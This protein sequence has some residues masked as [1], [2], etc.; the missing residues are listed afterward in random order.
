M[1]ESTKVNDHP[2]TEQSGPASETAR[3]VVK[4]LIR[5]S[6]GVLFVAA[7]LFIPAGRLDWAMGWALVGIYA[8][9]VTASAVILIPRSPELLAERAARRKGVRGWDTALLGV[10]GLATVAKYVI[11]G[12]DMRFGWTPPMPVWLQIAALVIAAL[13]YALLTWSMAANA[14]FSTVVRIQDDRGHAVV[15]GGPYR[16]VRHPGYSGSLAFEL[17]T[18]IMLGS[19]WALIPGGLNALLIVIRTALEDRTLNEELD[20][21]REYVGQVRYRLLP[22]VW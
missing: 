12:L 17:A 5:E 11:A 10:I 14:F 8:A 6:I 22:G 2:S 15:S 13:G 4:W 9:W 16:F 18:P 19:P 21:Y 20:G 3:G 1:N 7:T